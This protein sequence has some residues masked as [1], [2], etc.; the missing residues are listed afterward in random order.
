[1]PTLPNLPVHEYPSLSQ[2]VVLIG[3]PGSGKSTIGKKLAV[4]MG[5]SFV[6]SDIEVEA[7]ADMTIPEIFEKLGEPAFRDGERKV[8]AR[9]LDGPPVILSTGG[10][11]FMN[12][13]TRELIKR[14][15]I[16]VWLKANLDILV[17]RTSRTNDRPLLR[18]GDPKE[19]LQKMMQTREPV[20]AQ[21]DLTVTSENTPIEITTDKVAAT[22]HLYLEGKTK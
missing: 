14:K 9:L 19:I 17:E 10:G 18:G 8:I 15:A 7:A 6:D 22:V 1:M 5:V 21:A 13:Q 3:M 16:S 2:S 11:A 20:Y 4:Q 12:E